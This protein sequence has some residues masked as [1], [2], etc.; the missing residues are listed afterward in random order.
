MV[1][2]GDK[3]VPSRS[4]SSFGGACLPFDMRTMKE[5][6]FF[7]CQWCIW[8]SEDRWNE[9]AISEICLFET[10]DESIEFLMGGLE[11]QRVPMDL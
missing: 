6:V 7:G 8:V 11:D 4:E 2:P 9:S 3:A 5:I 1:A 10:G